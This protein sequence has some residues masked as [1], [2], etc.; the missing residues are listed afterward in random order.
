MAAESKGTD[1]AA[2]RRSE[3]F[4]HNYQSP[5]DS[6]LFLLMVVVVIVGGK[7]QRYLLGL[8][9]GEPIRGVV[10]SGDGASA[11]TA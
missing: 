11:C 4:H 1:E 6:K 10:K 8:F 3:R 5:L 9:D 2:D 7:D